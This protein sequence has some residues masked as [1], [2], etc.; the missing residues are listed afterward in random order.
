M[1][2]GKRIIE[3]AIENGA[4]LAGIA[5]MEALKISASH[6]IYNKMMDCAGINPVKDVEGLPDNEFITDDQSLQGKELFTWP[7]SVKSILVIGLSHP[8][9]NPE[10]DWWDGRG[11]LGNRI[12]IDIIK[13]TSQQIDNYMKVRTRKLHYYVEKGGIFLKDAAALAGLGCI[14]KNNML[15]TP[16][17]GPRIRL[18]A[19]FLDA[20]IQPTGPIDFDPCAACKVHCRR[21]C[22]EN[23]MTEKASMFESIEF[24]EP[25]PGRDGTY[26]RELCNKRMKKD[27]TESTRNNSDKEPTIKFC[28]KCEFICPVGKRRTV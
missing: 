20:K 24:Y 14:G 22:P 25:L 19:L 17:N 12:L 26:S 23:A 9:D 1:S 16:S 27:I 10:L 11:T 3:T 7:D 6:M 8:K 28:R 15:I 18:R 2:I 4:T 13:R 21:V 5:S